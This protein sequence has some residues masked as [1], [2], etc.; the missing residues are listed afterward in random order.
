MAKFE[1]AV[2]E[3]FGNKDVYRHW[4]SARGHIPAVGGEKLAPLAAKLDDKREEIEF[5]KREA[6]EALKPS[7]IEKP[8]AGE[9][10]DEI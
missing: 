8:E 9:M 3:I 6:L 7:I 2:K 10:I 1:A 5:E 4:L